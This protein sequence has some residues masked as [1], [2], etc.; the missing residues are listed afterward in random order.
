M[1]NVC[2]GGSEAV[3]SCVR[4]YMASKDGLCVCA[5]V[6]VNTYARVEHLRGSWARLCEQGWRLPA[7]GS[8]YGHV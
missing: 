7:G 1:W 8:V 4:E 6:P 5:F 2:A 3:S